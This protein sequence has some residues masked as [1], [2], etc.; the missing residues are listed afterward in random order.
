MKQYGAYVSISSD[1]FL[2]QVITDNATCFPVI[3]SSNWLIQFGMPGQPPHHTYGTVLL[4]TS[5]IYSYP[6]PIHTRYTFLLSASQF[7]VTS[8]S[9]IP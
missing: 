2:V 1:P 9:I 5:P 4:E 8:P 7:A 3:E 6:E